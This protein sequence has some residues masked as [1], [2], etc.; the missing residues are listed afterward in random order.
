MNTFHLAID[1]MLLSFCEDCESNDGTI[2]KPYYMSDS[3]L[4][5]VDTANKN[6][7][8]QITVK[9]TKVKLVHGESD[10]IWRVQIVDE[11]EKPAVQTP[12]VAQPPQVVVLQQPQAIQPQ[13]VQPQAAPATMMMAP[14]GAIMMPQMSGAPVMMPQQ[15]NAGVPMVMVQQQNGQMVMMPMSQIQGYAPQAVYQ[16]K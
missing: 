4:S 16:P 10:W 11:D 7:V 9:P 3:L 8:R 5:F 14:G 6:S 13:I 2:E 15:G 1:T 12:I